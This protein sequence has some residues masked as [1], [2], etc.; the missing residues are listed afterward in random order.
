MDCLASSGNLD[1]YAFAVDR[2]RNMPQEEV[3]PVPLL[4]GRELIAAG[5]RPGAEFKTML[6]AV[7]E[8]QLE[9]TIHTTEEAM[10]LVLAQYPR[11]SEQAVDA[12]SAATDGA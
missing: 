12:S 11:I 4:T 5:Y 10:E 9:G 7:E 3:R 6:H 2:Y 8:A 1:H